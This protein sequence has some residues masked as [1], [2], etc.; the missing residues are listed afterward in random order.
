[1]RL[2]LYRQTSENT[3]ISNFI[4]V[5]PVGVELFRADWRADDGDDAVII[6]SRNSYEHD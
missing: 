3:H 6:A 4:N 1:M 5:R 2:E